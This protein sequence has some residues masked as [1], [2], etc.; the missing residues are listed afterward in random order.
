MQ[1]RIR[2]AHVFGTGLMT[3]ALSLAGCCPTEGQTCPP[4]GP[5][6]P[7]KPAKASICRPAPAASAARAGDCAHLTQAGQAGLLGDSGRTYAPPIELPARCAPQGEVQGEVAYNLGQGVITNS[8]AVQLAGGARQ[9]TAIKV[10]GGVRNCCN[11]PPDRY[12]AAV[13]ANRAPVPPA[14][15]APAAPATRVASVA[16]PA[17][18]A[19][20][21]AEGTAALIANPPPPGICPVLTDSLGLCL[22]GDNLGQCYTLPEGTETSGPELYRPAD[23]APVAQVAAPVAA[24]AAPVAPPPAVAGKY[25]GVAATE[26]PAPPAEKA[27]PAK[28]AVVA[29]RNGGASGAKTE[30][31]PPVP[32]VTDMDAAVDALLSGDAGK[33]S[34]LPSVEL[35]PKL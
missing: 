29:V 26:I 17:F 15:A 18:P 6:K 7:P 20:P 23:P 1:P 22:P 9:A 25:A 4:A 27:V 11:P 32:E 35:P 3:M 8:C 34:S 14:P 19:A 2:L 5:P 24:P 30:S 16:A 10:P 28:T 31:F 12:Y 13:A 33:T 21:A